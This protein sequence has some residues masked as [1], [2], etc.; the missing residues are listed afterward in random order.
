MLNLDLATMELLICLWRVYSLGREGLST[1]PVMCFALVLTQIRH[2]IP[3]QSHLSELPHSLLQHPIFILRR[4]LD[5]R[6]RYKFLRVVY[7]TFYDPTLVHFSAICARSLCG[8]YFLHPARHPTTWKPIDHLPVQAKIKAFVVWWHV[9]DKSPERDK[10][11]L[12][13]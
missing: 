2:F 11:M 8:M 4:C 13:W 10:E 1:D 12:Q 7:K 5:F 3:L 9:K 6:V